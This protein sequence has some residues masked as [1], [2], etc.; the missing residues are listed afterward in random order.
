MENVRETVDLLVK[1][2]RNA[3]ESFLSYDQEQVDNIVKNMAIKALSKHGELAKAAVEETGM[4][5]YEDKITKNIF[6]SE[7]V[8]HSIKNMKTVGIINDNDEL[9]EVINNYS[10]NE[11]TGESAPNNVTATATDNSKKSE[12]PIRAAGAAILC[13]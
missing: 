3:Y 1:R 12:A 5:I 4:G 2:A 11:T 9:H 7:Y 6:A 8:Y 10:I 13:G